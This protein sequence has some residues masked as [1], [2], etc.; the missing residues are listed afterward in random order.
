MAE[1]SSQILLE[2]LAVTFTELE[3]QANVIKAMARAANVKAERIQ[4]SHGD[5]VLSS[6]LVAKAQTLHALVLLE[7]EKSINAGGK[8]DGAGKRTV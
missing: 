7:K 6:I 3:R 1:I 2:E 8:Q 5:L 4:D